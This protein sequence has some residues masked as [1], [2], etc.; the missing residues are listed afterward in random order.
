MSSGSSRRNSSSSSSVVSLRCRATRRSGCPGRHRCA[1]RPSGLLIMISP[2]PVPPEGSV[3]TGTPSVCDSQAAI[4]SAV[5]FPSSALTVPPVTGPDGWS[6]VAASSD[7]H[8]V[9]RVQLRSVSPG[10]YPAA[11]LVRVSRGA[12]AAAASVIRRWASA[13]IGSSAGLSGGIPGHQVTTGVSGSSSGVTTESACWPSDPYMRSSTVSP[14]AVSPTRISASSRDRSLGR[15]MITTRIRHG[16]WRAAT[17]AARTASYCS[18]SS[19]TMTSVRTIPLATPPRRSRACRSASLMATVVVSVRSIIIA[20]APPLPGRSESQSPPCPSIPGHQ[21]VRAWRPGR[22]RRVLLRLAML[23]PELLDGVEHL[24]RQLD[25]PVPW[26]QW[27]VADEHV[28][29]QPLIRFG[30]VLGERL[31]VGEVHVHVPDL[32]RGAGDLGTEPDR[33]ALVRLH[34]DHHGV[35]PELL[36]IGGAERQ[37][38]RPL[39]QQRYLGHPARQPFAGA[40]VER[41]ARPPPGVHGQPDRGVVLGMGVRRDPVLLEEPGHLHAALPARRVL[42]AG[43]SRGQVLGQPD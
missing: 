38:R 20:A 28:E 17:V 33:H 32:H 6:I 10:W 7:R 5:G 16:C 9:A 15:R 39:E 41:D 25:L 12:S 36:G 43:G 23:G 19:V 4:R 8:G 22:P 3:A 42:A 24:P 27:R 34:P 18:P 14:G 2:S 29:Q 26:K 11:S 13:P 31:A 37:V 40:Q 21:R 35:L 1:T 30:A